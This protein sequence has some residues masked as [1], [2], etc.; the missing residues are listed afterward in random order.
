MPDS[1]RTLEIQLLGMTLNVVCGEAE[2][3]ALR[4]A[5]RLFDDYLQPIVDAG[6]VVGNERIAILAGLNLAN[7]FNKLRGA[8]P[9]ASPSPSATATLARCHALVDALLADDVA[10]PASRA[11]AAS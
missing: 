9:A 6:K 7:E 10:P 5:V 3:P 1:P 11:D 2:E 4:A 8:A